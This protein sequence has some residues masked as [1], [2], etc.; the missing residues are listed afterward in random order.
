MSHIG[1]I[2]PDGISDEKLQQV[3]GANLTRSVPLLRVDAKEE[4]FQWRPLDSPRGVEPTKFWE[5]SFV[6]SPALVSRNPHLH[7]SALAW[8]SDTYTLGT[9]LDANPSKVG[10]QMRNVTSK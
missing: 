6:R 5:R 4:P 1:G 7:Q 8:L 3:M 2:Q 10:K 9:P